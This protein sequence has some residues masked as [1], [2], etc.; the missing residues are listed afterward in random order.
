LKFLLDENVPY[1]LYRFLKEQK[2]DVVRAQNIQRGLPDTELLKIAKN[3]D[4]ILVTLDK[5][6]A[7]LY[8]LE[9]TT[10]IVLIDIHPPFPTSIITVFR[11][12]LEVKSILKDPGLIVAGR[13]TIRKIRV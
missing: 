5:D 3:E 6:F 9:P 13:K 11:R 12:L 8:L 7:R 4:R 10:T 1:S 2:Y